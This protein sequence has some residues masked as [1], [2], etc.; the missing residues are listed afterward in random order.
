[1]PKRIHSASFKAKE[2]M[3]AIKDLYGVV[4]LTADESAWYSQF[5]GSPWNH[6]FLV[7]CFQAENWRCSSLWEE[8]FGECYRKLV[9]PDPH[10]LASRRRD[11]HDGLS[12]FH[13]FPVCHNLPA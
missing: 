10:W 7:S 6:K 11:L 8:Q 9:D 1:M 4:S 12:V 2:A 13:F 5:S 3:E